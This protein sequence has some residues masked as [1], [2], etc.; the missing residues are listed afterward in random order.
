MKMSCRTIQ[1]E[2][3]HTVLH[4]GGVIPTSSLCWPL[5]TAIPTIPHYH[6]YPL[7]SQKTN[8]TKVNDLFQNLNIK[9]HSKCKKPATNTPTNRLAM[10]KWQPHKHTRKATQVKTMSL[11]H[12]IACNCLLRKKRKV[13]PCGTVNGA[14]AKPTR[15]AHLH[16][17]CAI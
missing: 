7:T 6:H 3:I 16:S 13:L 2:I 14:S 15:H 17:R 12:T 9:A 1:R 10:G 4:D 8:S 11:K 5:H